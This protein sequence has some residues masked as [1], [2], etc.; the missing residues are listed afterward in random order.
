MVLTRALCR[1]A[2]RSA[3]V[4]SLAPGRPPKRIGAERICVSIAMLLPSRPFPRKTGP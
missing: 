3:F 2:E 4:R 1:L